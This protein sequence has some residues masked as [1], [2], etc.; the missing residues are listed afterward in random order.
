[1]SGLHQGI[2]LV[3]ALLLAGC[4]GTKAYPDLPEKNLQVRASLSG[5]KAVMGVHRLDAQC[6]AFYEGVVQL[7]RSPLDVGLPP[8]RPS[9]LVFEFYSSSFLSGSHSISKEVRLVPRPGY[10]YEALVTYKDSL[11]DVRLREIDPRSGAAR[12]LDTRR[13][14]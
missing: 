1:M 4:A 6:N 13:G 7:D 2:A 5:S 3:A 8:G 12:E 11:Y 14:C 10:R 9:L